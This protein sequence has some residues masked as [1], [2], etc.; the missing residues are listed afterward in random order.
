MDLPR[1]LS[2]F[3]VLLLLSALFSGGEVALL[4]PPPEWLS[5]KMG[6][7][8]LPLV[9]VPEAV[10]LPV[11]VGNTLVNAYLAALF[12]S[13]T[14]GLWP[15][16]LHELLAAFLVSML[17]FLVSELPP[18]LLAYRAPVLLAR[19]AALLIYPVGWVLS[20]ILRRTGRVEMG[21]LRED[22]R[23]VLATLRSW[24]EE[25]QDV[26]ERE[27]ADL[28]EASLNFLEGVVGDV[29]TPR[30][31]IAAIPRSADR[32]TVLDLYRRTRHHSYPVYDQD[33]NHIVGIFSIKRFLC[34]ETP[35]L[36][37]QFV[38][39]TTPLVEVFDH[40]R[41]TR[42]PMM[43]V[44]DE[45]GNTRG[46]VTLRD[47]IRH[48]VRQ[49]REE[50]QR[51]RGP[52]VKILDAQSVLVRAD[53]SLDEVEGLLGVSFP[54]LPYETLNGFLIKEFRRIPG[55]GDVLDW[56]GLRF[57]VLQAEPTR[58]RWVKITRRRTGE[59]EA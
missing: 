52:R 2:L 19:P 8:I 41:K 6:R 56:N 5:R 29:M 48:F 15:P 17:V 59:V 24:V 10:I 46:I 50:D 37:P 58:A 43:I 27:Q 14:R 28:L 26:G 51:D 9:Q 35:I 20:R 33:L 40:F 36:P 45:Y 42:H 55:E 25:L 12:D 38:V 34:E 11:L 4:M 54:P 39:D 22:P 21:D 32:E 57:E 18:K 7:W 30:P 47:V 49:T 44:V 3:L 23:Q 16:S 53:I 31:R 1:S 13:M